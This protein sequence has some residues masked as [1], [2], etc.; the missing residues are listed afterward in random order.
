MTKRNRLLFITLQMPLADVLI[1]GE[2]HK[3]ER[4]FHIVLKK[5]AYNILI[6]FLLFLLLFQH[7]NLE[8]KPISNASRL[9]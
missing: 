6:F 8:L 1:E 5:A 4:Y 2:S 7:N 3:M 9:I